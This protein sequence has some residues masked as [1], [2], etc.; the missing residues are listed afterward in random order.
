M[1]TTTTRATTTTSATKAKTTARRRIAAALAALAAALA[2]PA[3]ALAQEFQKVDGKVADEIP[4][5]PF[6]GI[7]YGFIWIAVL[8]YVVYVARGL[9]RVKGEVD[10]LRRQLDASAGGSGAREAMRK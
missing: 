5:V 4:A 9:S 6:V 10:E 3:L 7:A 1:T 2:A 8:A